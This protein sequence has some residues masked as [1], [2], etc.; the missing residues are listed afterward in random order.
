MQ[1]KQANVD[2]RV[3]KIE[4]LVWLI[5]ESVRRHENNIV[6]ITELFNEGDGIIRSASTKTSD[7]VPHI[8]AV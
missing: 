4:D 2:D 3:L 7:G 8:P 6:R 1:P 5:D